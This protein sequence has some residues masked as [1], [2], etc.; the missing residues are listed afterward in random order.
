MKLHGLLRK[1]RFNDEFQLVLHDGNGKSKEK[2]VTLYMP[3]SEA[4][5]LEKLMKKSVKTKRG[6]SKFCLT[7]AERKSKET[8]PLVK[9]QEWEDE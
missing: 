7:L 8:Y 9:G 5:E 1:S 4:R 2:V 3:F 6:Y